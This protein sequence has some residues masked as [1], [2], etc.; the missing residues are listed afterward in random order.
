MIPRL[1]KQLSAY[2]SLALPSPQRQAL[3][4]LEGHLSI[5]SSHQLACLCLR[6]CVLPGLCGGEEEA[7]WLGQEEGTI[8][9]VWVPSSWW[10]WVAAPPQCLRSLHLTLS[11]QGIR[12]AID[13]IDASP[14][15]SSPEADRM[16]CSLSNL[17]LY[18]VMWR[19]ALGRWALGRGV[20]P[21]RKLQPPLPGAESYLTGYTEVPRE[22]V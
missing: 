20:G 18:L 11:G 1:G 4:D 8:G 16:P 21:L 19:A 13:I 14:G 15:L 7:S 10:V 3:L 17:Y 12:I 6:C 9:G 5:Y 22:V 2:S